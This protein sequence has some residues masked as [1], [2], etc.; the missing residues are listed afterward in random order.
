MTPEPGPALTEK[1]IGLAIK[2]HR[3]LGPGLLE[4]VYSECLAWELQ[5]HGFQTERE[6]PIPVVYEGQRL[7]KGFYADIVVERTALLE[8]KT[9]ERILPIHEAQTRTYLRLSNCRIGLLLNFNAVLLK[10]GIRRFIP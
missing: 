10:D 7:P 4:S 6:V 5:Q 3:A 2:V 9:V 8:L 1:I